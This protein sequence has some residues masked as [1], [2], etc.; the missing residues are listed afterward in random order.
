MLKFKVLGH[1]PFSSIGFLASFHWADET[2]F[3]FVGASSDSFFVIILIG[4]LLLFSKGGDGIGQFFLFM[5]FF[6]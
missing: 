6:A 4:S 5:Q 1:G 3:D 2:S